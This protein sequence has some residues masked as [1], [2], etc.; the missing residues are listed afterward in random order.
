MRLTSIAFF[1]R[2]H[3]VCPFKFEENRGRTRRKSRRQPQRPR[4][5]I[6]FSVG[7]MDEAREAV[8]VRV[9]VLGR[10]AQGLGTQ[11]RGGSTQCT[12]SQTRRDLCAPSC[13][14]HAATGRRP[15]ESAQTAHVLARAF[16]LGRRIE[17]VRCKA[18]AVLGDDESSAS[19]SRNR[20]RGVSCRCDQ[21]DVREDGAC[22]QSV[23][24]ARWKGIR[25]SLPRARFEDAARCEER[26]RL[27]VA[28]C[29][30]SRHSL[31]RSGSVLVGSVVRRMEGRYSSGLRM[32]HLAVAESAYLAARAR[33]APTW[34]DRNPCT[35][36][37]LEFR[38]TLAAR[39]CF[40][41]RS[42][43]AGAVTCVPGAPA[44]NCSPNVL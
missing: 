21:R 22:S 25:V 33:L 15:R 6:V 44:A 8:D 37:G 9:W 14:C 40:H 20:E 29:G 4:T 31:R 1:S 11:A 12:A 39:S 28:Q 34:V 26:A 5:P 30:S 2:D 36:E 3:D 16:G 38:V 7:A 41:D 19:G 35:G 10:S 43:C 13:A 23:M 24:G 17:S 18:R 42:A 27:R 32:V